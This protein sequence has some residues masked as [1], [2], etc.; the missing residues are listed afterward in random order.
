MQS[1]DKYSSNSINIRKCIHDM[2][3]EVLNSLTLQKFS[4]N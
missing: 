1:D 2:F 3:N 4:Q